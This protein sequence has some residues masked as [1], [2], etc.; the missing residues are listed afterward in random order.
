MPTYDYVC[1]TNG[2]EVAV[3]HA[4]STRLAT[5]GELCD[6]ASIDVGETARSAPVERQIGTGFVLAKRPDQL[7]GLDG[8]CCGVHGCG[9]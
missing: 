6:L 9:D 5:W 8:G 2:R 7:A 3:F 4:M 1:P